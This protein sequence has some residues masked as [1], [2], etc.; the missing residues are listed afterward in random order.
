M[1]DRRLSAGS[2]WRRWDPHIHCPGTALNDQYDGDDPWAAFLT[3][4]E[5]ASPTVEA[6]GVT[7]YYSID[8]YQQL[9]AHKD[10]GRLSDVGLIFPNI[11]MR[12]GI[13]TDAGSP[14]N[15]HL[16]VSPEDP[17]H[18]EQI[19]RFLTRLTFKTPGETYRCDRAD[20]IRLGKQH[21]PSTSDDG[22]AHEIG[23]NQFKVN[24]DQ[25]LE[26]W[27]ASDWIQ[28]NALI[29]I[30]GGSSD[31]SSGLAND[32]SL[33]ALR[34]KIE[35]VAH[36]V[37]AAQP[38]QRTFWLGQGVLSVEQIKEKYRAL[39]PCLHGSDAHTLAQ[40]GKPVK[41]RFSWVKGDAT[42]EALRHA[43]M[44][45]EA[46]TYIGS[47]APSG[48]QSSQVIRSVTVDKAPWF[49]AGTVPINPGLVGI[50]GARGSGKTALADMIAAGTYALSEHVSERSFVKRAENL[51]TDAR[52]VV[53]WQDGDPTDN[54][55]KHVDL[56]EI[57][58]T[59]RVQYL[60]QQFV[61]N[62]CSA[63]GA[64]D[65]LLIEIERVIFQA[66]PSDERLGTHNFQELLTERASLGRQ[67]RRSHEQ[68]IADV[69]EELSRERDKRDVLGTLKAN[70]VAA[71]KIVVNNQRDRK[72]LITKDGETR[73]KEFDRVSAA[74]ETLRSSIEQARR[75]LG[76]LRLLEADVKDR[77]DN[78]APAELRR[79]K[80]DHRETALD[81]NT[82]A[83]FLTD[84]SGD[85]TTALNKEIVAVEKDIQTRSGP[86]K[87]EPA[88][89]EG[90]TTTTSLLPDGVALDTLTL[91]LLDNEV[92]RLAKLI[93]VD[94]SKQKAFAKLTEKISRQEAAIVK[95]DRDITSAEA[96]GAR[97]QSLI[98]LR[99]KSYVGV[100]NGVVDEERA[101]KDL[102]AP[103]AQRLSEEDGAL[104]KLSFSIRRNV[105][106][107][108]WAAAGEALFDLRKAGGFRGRGAL[109]DVATA[110]LLEPWK[111]GTAEEVATAMAGFR[112]DY[113]ETFK[114][115]AP[116][117]R[118]NLKAYRQWAAQVSEWLYSTHHIQMSYGLQYEGLEIERLSPGT[119]GIVLLLLYLA[120]DN[121][122]DRPLIID[123]P[124]ENL[125]PKSIFDELVSR[126]RAAKLRRQIIIVTHNANLV[127]NTD[128]EQVI[129]ATCGPHRPNELPDITY[130]TGSL[131]DPEIRRYVCDILE[132]GEEAF[133]ERARRLR[134]QLQP[135]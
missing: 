98:E 101:L 6:I 50:I 58:D 21:D 91:S 13:G 121:E 113:D 78:R 7:D 33:A 83:L 123:Q 133:R 17:D 44:E 82:W 46:R 89:I 34:Q 62:L 88:F 107:A 65:E 96:A 54:E 24:V 45:P 111:T 47:A 127:V 15:F 18:V 28:N 134:V 32:A 63:E 53:Q 23:V 76:A 61:D 67:Q 9:V 42:F 106:V 124:E 57:L 38:K 109:L 104:A 99:K 51:L 10:A 73:T 40:V 97:I 86:A 64:S 2:V 49:T 116:V 130:Q 29:A 95:L 14:V 12:Y 68:A 93:G 85:V 20:L 69:G 1:S 77:R 119:R 5:N 110:Q 48:A 66:H 132:G 26:E 112:A 74:A 129:V 87:D 22:A 43:C 27:D 102:Y 70:R 80:Q 81:E 16:L 115:A 11:E 128:A 84:Y 79:L 41:D 72:K 19:H 25:L 39:K 75:R 56:E 90:E 131:E 117:E 94:Q 71:A 105:D 135:R 108:A 100:F 125:D 35:R 30:A 92:K 52:A 36:I 3:D 120:I 118:K 103:L 114:A 8:T 126:F 55:L 59:P 4:L 37:F 60:S 122:D 31:G